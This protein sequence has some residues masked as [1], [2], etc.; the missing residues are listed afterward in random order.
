MSIKGWLLSLGSVFIVYMILLVRE[1][2]QASRGGY[3]VGLP[4]FLAVL[5]RPLL[6][7]IALPIF[8]LIFWATFRRGPN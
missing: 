4:V 3:A 6:W 1:I 7:L 8:F 5:L 2:A